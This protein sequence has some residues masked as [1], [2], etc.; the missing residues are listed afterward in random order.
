[1]P[2]FTPI[3]SLAV[4]GEKLGMD[5]RIGQLACCGLGWEPFF[6]GAV[7]LSNA[8][9]DSTKGLPYMGTTRRKHMSGVRG[10]TREAYVSC[11]S[12]FPYR[13]YIDSNHSDSQI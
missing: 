3:A 2:D 10:L 7:A 5:L 12:D 8:V 13:V 6:S 9:D 11:V 1:M 4:V